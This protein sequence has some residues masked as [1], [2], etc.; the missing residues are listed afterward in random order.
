MVENKYFIEYL[1]R[2]GAMTFE[3]MPFGEVDNLILSQLAYL[4]YAGVIGDRGMFLCDVAIKYYSI[5]DDEYIS[6]LVGISQKAADLLMQ[7]AKTNRF[8][9]VTMS[10]YINFVDPDLDEQLGA[11]TFVLN[12]NDIA[13]AFRG[14]DV[15]ITGIKESATMSY[16]FPVPGQIGA[17]EY[18]QFIA[19][20]YKGSII[21]CG[22][23][24]GGNLAMYAGVCCSN[25]IKERITAIYQDDAPGFNEAFYDSKEYRAVEGITVLFTPQSS[26]VG[27]LLYHAEKP[28][29]IEST[30]TGIKQHQ[31]SSWVIEDDHLKR[32]KKYD[33]YSQFVDSYI[34]ELLVYVGRE[35]LAL[36][37][38]TIDYVATKM[39][40]D[41][42]YD[43]KNM[44]LKKIFSLV[45]S[46]TIL[47]D[48]QKGRFKMILKKVSMDFSRKYFSDKAKSYTALFKGYFAKPSAIEE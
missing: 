6:K 1:D 31:V 3:Q 47:D 5:H 33:L 10:D 27:R 36:F 40:V 44:D 7:C 43:V 23:S 2:F 46:V 13:V 21:L 18:L 19:S 26:V 28:I 15:T 16:K 11:V 48:E 14:T 9:Y 45:D 39:G 22:H 25:A 20:N 4:D 38:D 17:L 37:F 30:N 12:K 41:D 8:G 29:I 34:D 42:F 32:A 24:K 35:D